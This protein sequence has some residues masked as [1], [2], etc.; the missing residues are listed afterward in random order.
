MGLTHLNVFPVATEQQVVGVLAIET[1]EGL[2]AQQQRMVLS[3][4]R[5]LRNFQGRLDYGERDIDRPA[6]PHL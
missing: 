3:I 6:G 1:R 5:I 2:D 4:P